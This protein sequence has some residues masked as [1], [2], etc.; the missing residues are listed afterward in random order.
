MG[1][2]RIKYPAIKKPY[3]QLWSQLLIDMATSSMKMTGTKTAESRN[4]H[5]MVVPAKLWSRMLA[6]EKKGDCDWNS[7]LSVGLQE[8]ASSLLQ[9]VVAV[10]GQDQE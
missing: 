10:R 4:I 8:H 7:S 9:R 1:G 6:G 5:T 2:G 3:L